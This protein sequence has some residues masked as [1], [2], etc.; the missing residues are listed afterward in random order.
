MEGIIFKVPHVSLFNS[1]SINSEWINE[2]SDDKNCY[3]NVGG[4]YNEDSAYNTYE[5]YGKN[6]FDNYWILNSDHCSNNIHG[7]RNYF[8][9]FSQESHDCLNVNFSYDC[10]N[11]SYCIGCAGLRNKKYY[12]FNKKHTKEEYDNFLKKNPFSSYSGVQ[13]WKNQSRKIWINFPHREN[14]MFKTINSTGNDLSET[15]NS[16]NCFQGT[17]LENCRNCFIIGWMKDSQDCNSFGAAELTYECAHSGGAYN[18]KGLLFA[19]LMIP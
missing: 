13:W 10:R 7:E 1:N 9:N 14:M 16:F 15:K 2:E 4:H 12:I 11:C 18:S 17:K 5:L 3:L 19:S 6:C 8:T